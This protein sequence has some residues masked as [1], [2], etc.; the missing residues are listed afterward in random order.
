M[1]VYV[2]PTCNVRLLPPPPPI[3]P[4]PCVSASGALVDREGG[5]VAAGQLPT[6]M[7]KQG[8]PTALIFKYDKASVTFD[9]SPLTIGERP[10]KCARVGDNVLGGNRGGWG[11]RGGGGLNQREEA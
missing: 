1:G 10:C 6:H 2:G 7:L 3:P 8:F 11:D 4:G 9:R 5:G